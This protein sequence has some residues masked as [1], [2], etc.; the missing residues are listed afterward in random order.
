MHDCI[1]SLLLQIYWI[2]MHL[3]CQSLLSSKLSG[4]MVQ[5]SEIIMGSYMSK[6]DF[7]NYVMLYNLNFETIII[8][9]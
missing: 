8:K 2:D 1:L 9:E 6:T 7:I 4:H 5:E 3:L